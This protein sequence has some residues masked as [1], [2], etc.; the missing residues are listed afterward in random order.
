MLAAICRQVNAP[1]SLEHVTLD[2]PKEE[3]IRLIVKAC[4]IC[5]SDIG[6]IK[7]YWDNPLPFLVGHEIAG[8]VESVGDKVR[9]FKKGD[10]VIS[11]LARSCGSCANCVSELE[12]ICASPPSLDGGEITDKDGHTIPPLMN[13]GGFAEEIVIH[14]RQL[15]AIP[16]TLS[17]EEAALLGCGVIT[18]FSSVMRVGQ[19]QPKD[20]IAVI[21]TGGVGINAISAARAA[22]AAR[23][24]AVDTASNKE[25]FCRHMGAT[26]FINPLSDEA[27]KISG[28]DL[29][30][31]AI[32]SAKSI[33]EAI[34]MIR[35]GGKVIVMG[36]PPDD[37]LAQINMA[38]LANEAKT[39]IGTKL[40]SA[41][42]RED[43]PQI[44]NLHQSGKINLAD[45]IS[46]R[47]PFAEINA[48]LEQA[49]KPDAKRVV[50]TFSG[51]T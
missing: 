31:V 34:L 22:E 39:I 29:V 42:I 12:V 23:I 40:G 33:S 26:D 20:R 19:V 43:I 44:I 32:G 35:P 1:L 45:L 7:G 16:D 5:H 36:M 28:L 27:Q 47:Y 13:S 15:I 51:E 3:S 38:N 41:M 49:T 50:L 37:D 24:I 11:T 2:A 8:I 6:F 14:E 46:H 18:G 9:H 4:A 25:D 17:F 10:R 21:G 48:A 30:F